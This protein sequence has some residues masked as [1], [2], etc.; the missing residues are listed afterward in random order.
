MHA[1]IRERAGADNFQ[2]LEKTPP[3]FPDP[4]S[5]SSRHWKAGILNTQTKKERSSIDLL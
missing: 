3:F 2:G 1:R 5:V 4:G